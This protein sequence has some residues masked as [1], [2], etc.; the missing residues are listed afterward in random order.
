MALV[1]PALYRSCMKAMGCLSGGFG[2]KSIFR[3]LGP[4]FEYGL[5]SAKSVVSALSRVV[6][7]SGI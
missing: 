2:Y 4:M 3:T 1:I 6:L 5:S 7:I